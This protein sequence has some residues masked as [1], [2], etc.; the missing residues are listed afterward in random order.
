MICPYCGGNND[1]VQTKCITCEKPLTPITK[2]EPLKKGPGRKPE[3]ELKQLPVVIKMAAFVLISAAVTEL[4]FIALEALI[5]G[6]ATVGNIG[7]YFL[8]I[9]LAVSLLK[10]KAW[11]RTWI[12]ARCFLGLV[13]FGG[14]S[15][16]SGDIAG[17]V[18]QTIYV[19]VITFLLFGIGSKKK[20][21]IL[22]VIYGLT[23]GIYVTVAGLG[24]AFL[25]THKDTSFSSDK[26]SFNIAKPSNQWIIITEK[27]FSRMLLQIPGEIVEVAHISRNVVVAVLVSQS[28]TPDI[29]F[30]GDTLAGEI[31]KDPRNT[32]TSRKRIVFNKMDAYELLYSTEAGGISTES[33]MIT[34]LSQGRVFGIFAT[35][36]KGLLK[37]Q[38]KEIEDILS[39]I[40]IG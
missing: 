38:S 33:R 18:I 11:A 14:M 5:V 22:G 7:P 17:L 10:R 31:A 20:A 16:A 34:V 25:G 35:G 23:L 39:S 24:Y 37:E 13:I 26:Y 19:A 1:D 27:D 2:D 32:I 36:L 15:I 29:G 3:K 40:K 8:D 21:V 12:L 28:D 4:I 6:R 30:I 9:F